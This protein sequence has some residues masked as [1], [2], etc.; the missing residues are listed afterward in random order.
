M[1][2]ELEAKEKII[3]TTTELIKMYGDVN[4][5][6]VR[7]IAQRS[8]VGVGL[9]NYH[10]ETK[11]KL[12]NQ[13]VQRIISLVIDGFKDLHKDLEISPIE[14]MRHLFKT[15]AAFVVKNPEI[16]RISMLH[17]LHSGYEGDNTHQ[18]G[19]AYLQLIKEV[20]R[21]EKSDKELY[22]I[23]HILT[24]AIQVAFLRSNIFQGSHGIDFFNTES[25]E[26]F[27]DLVIDSVLYKV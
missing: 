14:R 13:C 15:T 25:R 9:I 17:D 23:M 4:K 22:I 27:I 16:S 20:Y 2:K 18:A 26:A 24:S 7:E 6:T 5:I 10:F 8:G 19:E 21:D 1:K 3:A 12:I 11:E